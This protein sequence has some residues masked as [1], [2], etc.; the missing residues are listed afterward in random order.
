MKKVY[1]VRH[2]QSEG[3]AKRFHQDDSAALTQKGIEQA[4][5]LGNR[6][7]SIEVG[8]IIASSFKRAKETAE[9]INK[10]LNKPIEYSDLLVERKRPTSIEGLEYI[11]EDA[12]KTKELIEENY[13]NPEFKHS[14]EE[15]FFEMKDR[16]IK[17][18]DYIRMRKEDNVL[19]VSHSDFIVC[20]IGVMIFGEK[21][22]SEED[23]QLN[24]ALKSNNTGIT[25]C[26]FTDRWRIR[27]WNDHAHLG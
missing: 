16:A 14:D 6:F 24:H 2:G 27:T 18:I 4:E 13:H 23:L 17:A 22:K 1:F 25:L 3:N 12:I 5:A 20:M 7:K 8:E 9:I 19:V 11:H 26:E 10:V 21:F 15:S